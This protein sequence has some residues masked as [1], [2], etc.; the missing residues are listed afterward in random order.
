MSSLTRTL[1]TRTLLVQS[2]HIF[3]ALP[4]RSYST[5]DPSQLAS[6]S[7]SSPS[8]S[9]SPSP[10]DSE[11]VR[12]PSKSSAMIDELVNHMRDDRNSTTSHGRVGRTTHSRDLDAYSK[13]K[14]VLAKGSGSRYGLPRTQPTSPERLWAHQPPVPYVE[15]VTTTSAR[16]FAVMNGFGGLAGAWKRLQRTLNENNVRKELR[17]GERFEARSDKRVR[18][19]SE[20][21]RRRFQVAVGKAVS[22]A[23]R[24][25]KNL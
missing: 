12:G 5:S 14:D 7:T 10:V 21:H 13:V 24:A 2:K 6:T 15:P 23:M 3:P 1:R 18:L 19:N 25:S 17:R 22:E 11:P 9:P 16:T 20:R 4:L 8:P